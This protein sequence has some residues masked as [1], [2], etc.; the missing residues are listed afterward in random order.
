MNILDIFI[1]V[2]LG[3]CLVR[4]I[5]RGIVKELTSIVGVFVGFYVAYNFYPVAAVLIS[6]FFTNE[7]YLNIVSFFLV[8]TILFL[9]VGLV[10]VILKHLFKAVALGWA[11]RLLGATFGSVKAVLIVSVLLVPVTTYLPQN[12]PVIKNSLLAPYATKI[13]QILVTV[14]PKEMKEKFR[15]N[16]NALKE[17]WKD[18]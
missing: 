3:F 17:T 13:S 4:G 12:S 7:A 10:G 2:I 11:D 8:F 1:L 9:A 16:I 15:E 14:V 5:F 6:R 18:L